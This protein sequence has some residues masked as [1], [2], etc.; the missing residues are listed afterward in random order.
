M[1][2]IV[3]LRILYRYHYSPNAD[4]F[5]PIWVDIVNLSLSQGKMD[6]L[7]NAVLLPLVKE[8]DNLIDADVVKNYKPVSNLVFLSRKSYG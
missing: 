2:S 8:L 6:C 4:L 1:V 5:I 7:T 3:L